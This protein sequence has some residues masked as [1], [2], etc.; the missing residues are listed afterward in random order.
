M[1]ALLTGR[2]ELKGDV[3]AVLKLLPMFR[4]DQA[5]FKI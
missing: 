1:K 4:L 3:G 2:I 5:R